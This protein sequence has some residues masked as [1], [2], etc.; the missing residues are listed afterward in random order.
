M[1]AVD[2]I[3]NGLKQV[4]P[5]FQPSDGQIETKIID[6]VGTYADT[7]KIERDRTLDII[8]QALASQKVTTI[9]YYRRKAVAFQS[10]DVLVYDPINQGGYY[11]TINVENQII[12]QAYIVG[13]TPNFTLLVNAVGNDGHLRKL[14]DDELSSFRTYFDAFQPLGLRLNITSLDVARISDPNI[15]IH[16]RAGADA[17]DVAN[18]INAA[19]LAYESTFRRTN[20][21]SLTEIV[22]VIQSISDVRAVG[23][24]NPVATETGLDGVT[25]TLYPQEGIF[26]LTSGA[27]IF[28]TVITTSHIKVLQ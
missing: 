20:A 21:V 7:E 3:L 9:E 8:Q 14:T 24:S 18:R 17:T 19:M 16:V 23:L 28:D 10:G 4:L 6:V 12:K 25:R 27:F 13:E 2:T 1:G 11:E 15:V 5:S 22:D 26:N